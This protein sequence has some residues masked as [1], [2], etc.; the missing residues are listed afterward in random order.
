MQIRVILVVLLS[1]RKSSLILS[2]F[3]VAGVVWGCQTT[4][5]QRVVDEKPVGSEAISNAD[6]PKLDKRW[7][8]A[9]NAEEHY[10]NSCPSGT[11]YVSPEDISLNAQP[12]EL[13]NVNST[14]ASPVDFLKSATLSGVEYVA[15]YHLTSDNPRFGGIS[16][17]ETLENGS[18][19]SVTDQG[20]F[21]WIGL[22]EFDHL[23]PVNAQM[24]VMRDAAG[25]PYDSKRAADS[26]GLAVS[27]GLAL[28]S[29]EQKHRV[30]AFDLT[31]CGG[32]A[33][34]SK[35]FDLVPG[36]DGV[37]KLGGNQG[38]EA[39]ALTRDGGLILGIEALKDGASQISI[40]PNQSFV[41]FEHK[42]SAGGGKKMT[43]S[44]YLPLNESEGLLYSLHRHYSPLTGTH[45]R[46]LQTSVS[47]GEN[48]KY[49]LGEPK[50]LL[51]LKPPGI[52]DN[53]EG[54]A[55]RREENGIIRLFIVSDDNFSPKQ[56]SL[57]LIF[58]VL[59]KAY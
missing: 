28:V 14:E 22:D 51:Y 25:N 33:R 50:E 5:S 40:S 48:D 39:L 16:G 37:E 30:E 6:V 45:I 3:A 29:F 46:L 43:G 42:L 58:N 44:D 10:N 21:L 52:S 27:D 35:I 57:L 49:S 12:V 11:P 13:L 59:P 17:L 20:D 53:F 23:L 9:E 7:L 36:E 1:V 41:D 24:S 18:L 8:V 4:S 47:L 54:I 26:E 2:A 31:T 56:R 32:N 34:A 19:L 55:V 38:M 15:G